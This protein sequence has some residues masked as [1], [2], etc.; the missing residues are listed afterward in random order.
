[1]GGQGVH[2][3]GNRRHQNREAMRSSLQ[4]PTAANTG[5]ELDEDGDGWTPVLCASADRS[6][7]YSKRSGSQPPSLAGSPVRKYGNP[8]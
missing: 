4:T 6:S 2:T 7:M 8:R 5:G 3:P 1:M